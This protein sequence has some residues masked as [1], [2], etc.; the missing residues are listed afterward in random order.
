MVH[1][2]TFHSFEKID[3]SFGIFAADCDGFCLIYNFKIEERYD[4]PL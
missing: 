4:V 3:I 2:L 1:V